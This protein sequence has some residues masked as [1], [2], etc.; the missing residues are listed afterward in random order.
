MTGT[1]IVG[2]DG[3]ETA[4]KAAS[5]AAAVA[6]GLGVEL[7][8]VSAHARDNTEVVE[9]GSETWVLDDAERALEV[10]SKVA[11]KLRKEHPDL[12]IRPLAVRGKPQYALIGEAERSGAGVLVVGNVGMKGLGRVLGSVASSVAHN[13]PCDVLIVRTA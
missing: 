11:D 9:I 2:V 7:T 12:S 5:R 8:V 13:A 10:A 6:A 4:F 1:V 3:S